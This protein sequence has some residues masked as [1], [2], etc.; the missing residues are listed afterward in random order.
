MEVLI[1]KYSGSSLMNKRKPKLTL[2]KAL[3]IAKYI[4]QSST[5]TKIVREGL[6]MTVKRRNSG[7]DVEKADNSERCEFWGKRGLRRRA[8]R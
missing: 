6:F 2:Q 7:I 3:G 4:N 8:E 5:M 1:L